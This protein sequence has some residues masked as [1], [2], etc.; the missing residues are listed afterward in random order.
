L[1]IEESLNAFIEREKLPSDYSRAAKT[2][3]IPLLE[4]V[5]NLVQAHQNSAS[6]P[7]VLGINGA[8]GSG[9]S[10]LSALIVS[11]CNDIYGIKS[12]CMSL[13]DFYLT[14]AKRTELSRSV[15][16]LLDTRGVPGTH[17]M[18]LL[19]DTLGKLKKGESCAIPSFDKA[20]DDRS[21]EEAWQS[22]DIALD[23]IILEGWCV[24]IPPQANNELIEPVNEL[25]RAQDS[26]AHW[27]QY[28]NTKLKDDYQWVFSQFNYLVMLKA[29]S[30]KQIYAWRCEQ[31]HK[32][33][34]K[35]RS[36]GLPEGGMNDAEID[37][38]IQHYQRI[39]E[40][41]VL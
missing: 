15:H 9:K 11:L 19:Q 8:Q 1:N 27:R 31:E 20:S 24:G 25:E 4:R 16:P 18:R 38:F 6:E 41:G 28:A 29:P 22:V 17:D 5:A 2:W 40:H 35:N 23:L 3:F 39:T 12:V 30:F 37:A 36:R 7:F 14:K 32:M 26:D 21:P 10:T 34:A 13:D 33:H